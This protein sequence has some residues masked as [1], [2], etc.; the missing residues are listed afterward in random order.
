MLRK[1]PARQCRFYSSASLLLLASAVFLWGLQAKIALNH[2]NQD[3]QISTSSA[4]KAFDR[5]RFKSDW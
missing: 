3:K 4:A 1:R 2:A 5:E